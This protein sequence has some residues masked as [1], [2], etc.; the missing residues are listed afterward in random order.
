MF[1]VVSN[2]FNLKLLSL[3]VVFVSALG[4]CSVCGGYGV[5]GVWGTSWLRVGRLWIED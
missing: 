4:V 5:W 3:E 1:L 2:G